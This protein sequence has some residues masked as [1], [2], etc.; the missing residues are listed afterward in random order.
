MLYA[1]LQSIG[2]VLYISSFRRVHEGTRWWNDDHILCRHIPRD[3]V[4]ASGSLS[5]FDLHTHAVQCFNE[6][7][8][9]PMLLVIVRVVEPGTNHATR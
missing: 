9:G 8:D 7:V 4:N 1:H 6:L 5:L 2:C 3:I